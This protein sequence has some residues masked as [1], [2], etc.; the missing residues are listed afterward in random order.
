MNPLR[1]AR[2]VRR[3]PPRPPPPTP[4][5]LLHTKPSPLLPFISTNPQH[6]RPCLRVPE[7][8]FFTLRTEHLAFTRTRP[9]PTAFP[10]KK[11][12]NYFGCSFSLRSSR[13][14][15]SP[16]YDAPAGPDN[17]MKR[18]PLP[19][20]VFPPDLPTHG[21][22]KDLRETPRPESASFPSHTEAARRHR[23]RTPHPP[24]LIPRR[25]RQLLLPHPP[26]PAGGTSKHPPP[27]IPS[28]RTVFPRIPQIPTLTTDP[29]PQQTPSVDPKIPMTPDRPTPRRPQSARTTPAAPADPVSTPGGSR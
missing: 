15:T 3:A 11:Y 20:P 6:P 21:N 4:A 9:F 5:V 18:H 13:R 17:P 14:A 22:P 24:T 12:P 26:A 10:S 1:R 23:N 8:A 7:S 25:D 19:S 2:P 27:V 28:T 16:S 29:L